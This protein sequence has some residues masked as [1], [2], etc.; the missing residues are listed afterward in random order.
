MLFKIQLL[1]KYLDG[2]IFKKIQQIFGTKNIFEV[3]K[4]AIFDGFFQNLGNG[5][6]WKNFS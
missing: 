3:E 6:Q 1:D 5:Y 4:L 2:N